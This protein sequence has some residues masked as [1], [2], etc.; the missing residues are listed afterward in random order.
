MRAVDIPREHRA[1]ALRGP[2]ALDR[3]V[4]LLCS[5][6]P[7]RKPKIVI[8]RNVY[9]NRRVFIDASLSVRIEEGAAIGPNTYI[10]DHDHGVERGPGLMEQALNSAPVRIGRGA[11]IGANV[12]ILKGVTIG[13]GAIVGA[14]SVVT[15]DVSAN[16]VAV[17]NPARKLKER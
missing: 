5:G 3:G 4:V 7:Q 9:L 16:A 17:G 10:T 11:W 6:P 8:E 2:C 14:G 12:T 13:G 1:I 15:R